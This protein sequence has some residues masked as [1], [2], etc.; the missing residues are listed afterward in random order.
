MTRPRNK[1]AVEIRPDDKGAVDEIVATNC[2][3]HVERMTTS[4]WFM[5]VTNK[6]GREWRFW[7]GARNYKSAVEF[8]QTEVDEPEHKARARAGK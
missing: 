1:S 8:T 2:A 4:L 6:D 7:F 5:S 3:L